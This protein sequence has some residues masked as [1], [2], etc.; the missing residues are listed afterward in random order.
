MVVINE[1]GLR[2]FASFTDALAAREKSEK[3]AIK[4][5]PFL[6]LEAYFGP[7]LGVINEIAFRQI[8]SFTDALA[9]R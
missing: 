1:F 5:F 2:W 4:C 7:Y 8:A 3:S 9:T 6:M